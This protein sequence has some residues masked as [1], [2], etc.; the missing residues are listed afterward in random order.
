MEKKEKESKSWEWSAFYLGCDITARTVGTSKGGCWECM[1]VAM[2]T[3]V[4][5]LVVY[6]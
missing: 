1:A 2:A 5:I 6:E 4:W 3:D